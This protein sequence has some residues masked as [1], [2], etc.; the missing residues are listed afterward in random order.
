MSLHVLTLLCA[1]T[2]TNAS[3]FWAS[4]WRDESTQLNSTQ[5]NST[6]SSLPENIAITMPSNLERKARRKRQTRLTFDT[7]DLT[8]PP[9][10]ANMS[11]AKVR[12]ELPRTRQ[13][14]QTP[15]SSS[16]Q[17]PDNDSGSDDVLSSSKKHRLTTPAARKANGKLPFKP[18]PTPAKS[19]QTQ[20]KA[21][22][23]SF[24]M[25]SH[26]QTFSWMLHLKQ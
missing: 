8:S 1:R 20:V 23:S 4:S 12:Y 9:P 21:D 17:L 11:P 22:G 7:V 15:A 13:T 26:L 19:S 14:R 18:L 3:I 16:V 2:Q 6:L 25:S 24:G 10:T 5:L